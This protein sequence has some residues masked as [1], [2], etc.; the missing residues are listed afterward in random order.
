MCSTYHRYCYV[1][2]KLPPSTS[3]FNDIL[4]APSMWNCKDSGD[5][6]TKI[7]T[8]GR[9]FFFPNDSSYQDLSIDSHIIDINV[10]KMEKSCDDVFFKFLEYEKTMFI[11]LYLHA[12]LII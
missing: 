7:P 11:L 4:S 10:S 3:Y 6:S 1:K 5:K 9:H 12:V 2:S 8:H